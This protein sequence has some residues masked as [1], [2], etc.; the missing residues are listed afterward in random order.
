MC[1]KVTHFFANMK[2]FSK[3]ILTFAIEFGVRG[4]HL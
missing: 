2:A 3:K 4:A 1:H